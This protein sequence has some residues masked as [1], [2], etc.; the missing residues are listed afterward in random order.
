MV[1]LN[2][3]FEKEKGKFST[4]PMHRQILGLT[5]SNKSCVDHINGDKLD[6]RKSNLTY[7]AS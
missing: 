4:Y 2:A 1:T 6:N 3:V 5:F 7:C